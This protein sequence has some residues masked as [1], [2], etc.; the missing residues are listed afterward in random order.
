[1]IHR[2]FHFSNSLLELAGQGLS[3]GEPGLSEARERA[4]EYKAWREGVWSWAAYCDKHGLDALKWADRW[5]QRIEGYD[6]QQSVAQKIS[7]Y[8]TKA[9]NRYGESFIMMRVPGGMR[10]SAGCC[11]RR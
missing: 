11:F 7:E 5:S 10:G 1:M 8:R 6:G 3:R 9:T 4:K 2:K